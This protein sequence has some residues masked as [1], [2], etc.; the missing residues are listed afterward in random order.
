MLVV[1]DT[2]PLSNLAIIGRLDLLQE[3]FTEVLMPTKVTHELSALRDLRARR[4]IDRA[5]ADGWLK[6][7]SLPDD[8]PFP[9]EL[10]D[11]DPGETEALRL[12]LLISAD[13]VLMDERDG[14]MRALELG[15]NTIGVMGVL[16]VGKKS[17]S[18]S[19][20]KDPYPP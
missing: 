8:A 19:S 12:A 9:P 6:E 14:R 7:I 18:I 16:L 1:S 17:G 3:Q 4:S 11:L 15:V 20:V 5:I 10:L 2:S 13:H